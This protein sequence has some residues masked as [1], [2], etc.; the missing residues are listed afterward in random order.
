MDPLDVK[1]DALSLYI[2]DMYMHERQARDT[3]RQLNMFIQKSSTS[4]W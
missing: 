3:Y 1:S 2:A 4:L